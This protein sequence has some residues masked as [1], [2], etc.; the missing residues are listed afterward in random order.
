MI[1]AVCILIFAIIIILFILLEN[2]SGDEIEE[3]NNNNMKN[4]INESTDNEANAQEVK[5]T[6]YMAKQSVYSYLDLINTSNSIYYNYNDNGEYVKISNGNE[7]I[8]NLLSQDFIQKNNITTDNIDNFIKK[9]DTKAFFIPLDVKYQKKD[10][11]YKYAIYGYITDLEYNVL[12]NIALIVNIDKEN[13]TFSIEPLNDTKNI[14][15]VDLSINEIKSIEVNDYNKINIDE[16]NE[17]YI[18]NEYLDTYK[19]MM[20][21][22]SEEAFNHLDEEYRTKKF[23]NIENFKKYIDK[24][25]KKIKSITLSKYQSNNIDDYTQYI[26]VDEDENYYIFNEKDLMNYTVLL[27]IYTTDIPQFTEKYNSSNDADKGLLNVRKIISALKMKDYNYI[28][29]RLDT[30]F[31]KNNFSSIDVFEEYMSK[32]LYDEND[33]TV[34]G[35][36]HNGDVHSY[37]IS[38]KDKNNENNP[39]ITKTINVRLEEGTDFIMSFNI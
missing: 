24:N 38:I 22:N 7:E 2:K 15:N 13:Y 35:D 9:I 26:C 18:S 11:F 28:Y 3:E 36:Q 30:T 12:Q 10:N 32:I 27:D 8:Y 34:K 16:I 21:S 4:T 33:I 37:T 25:A 20:L 19:K 23:G 5:E 17:E 39:T 1:I 29:N 31:K 14:Q 6:F